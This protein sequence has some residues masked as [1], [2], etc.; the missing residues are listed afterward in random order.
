[1]SDETKRRQTGDNRLL[2]AL[3][4]DER[5]RFLPRLER[6][7]LIQGEPLFEAGALIEYVYFPRSGLFSMLIAMEDGAAI[8][9]GTVGNEGLIGLPVFLG[10][11]R[12]PTK[13][14]CQIAG[15]ADRM[16]T[17]AFKEAIGRGET[18][19][20]LTLRYTQ[21]VLSQISQ[22]AACNHLHLVEQR[23]AR[24]LLMAQDRVE[25][26]EV[27]LTQEFLAQMLGVRRPSVS[28][29]AARL[30]D[31]GLIHYHRGLITVLDRTRLEAVSCECYRTVKNE[32]DRLL[33]GGPT[34]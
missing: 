2:A 21:A 18:L 29:V 14:F 30:Q 6:V 10:A 34:V 11:E 15:E 28:V 25:G 33:G 26:H 1:M 3:P 19:A 20:A 4:R 22:S 7:S 5:E 16:T 9:V 27:P 32:Y 23:M 8:E 17:R 31:A 13:V 24:W 12:S